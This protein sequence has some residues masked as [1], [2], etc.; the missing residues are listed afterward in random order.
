[1][2]NYRRANIAGA[3]YFFTANLADRRETLLTDHIGLLRAAFQYVRDRHPYTTE[4]I[5]ILPEHLHVIWTLPAGDAD[6][7]TRWRL[8]KTEFSRRLP[9][10]ERRTASRADKGERGI[11]Q[12]RYWEHLI[13][14]EQDFARHVDYI[15]MNP[16][17]HGYVQ[18]VSDWPYSSFQRFVEA[19]MLPPDWGGGAD[20]KVNCGERE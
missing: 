5:A 6:F 4:A 15:H 17:K 9:E 14:D 10:G 18:R 11:W 12:R 20:M 7:S 2:T 3:A 1:M 19:G 13:R 16:V 8:L